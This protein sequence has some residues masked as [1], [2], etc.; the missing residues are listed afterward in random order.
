MYFFL[1]LHHILLW[2]HLGNLGPNLSAVVFTKLIT[3]NHGAYCRSSLL[4][5]DP[6]HPVPSL[7]ASCDVIGPNTQNSICRAF[8][9]FLF[10]APFV[11]VGV[12]VC[13]SVWN[14][15]V[16]IHNSLTTCGSIIFVRVL[17]RNTSLAAFLTKTLL[18]NNMRN[19]WMFDSK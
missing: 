10:E 11:G 18:L 5:V 6:R 16:E 4:S 19:V 2:D 17:K 12:C 7:I 15:T 13:V 3:L 1:C 14:P 8:Q 9:V